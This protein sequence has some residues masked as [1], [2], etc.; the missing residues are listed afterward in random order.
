[1]GTHKLGLDLYN[2]RRTC[3]KKGPPGWPPSGVF[4]FNIFDALQDAYD[5]GCL[6]GTN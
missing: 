1:M 4:A 2:L 5:R 6:F 3:L